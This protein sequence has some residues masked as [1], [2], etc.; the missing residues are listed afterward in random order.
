MVF[1]S[2]KGTVYMHIAYP[3][4]PGG[5]VTI[6][7]EET[8]KKHDIT[9]IGLRAGIRIMSKLQMGKGGHHFLNVLRDD[10]DAETAD[11]FLQCVVF[12]KVIYG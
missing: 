5:I 9:R 11:V 7:D 8:G 10:W 2:D 1:R 4:N 12:G 3:M 6:Q